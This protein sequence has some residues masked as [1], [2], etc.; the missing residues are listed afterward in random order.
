MSKETS[1]I[2]KPGSKSPQES[3]V[4]QVDKTSALIKVS[5]PEPS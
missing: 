5:L 1:S 4:I 2:N 3:F